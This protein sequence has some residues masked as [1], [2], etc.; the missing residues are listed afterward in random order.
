MAEHYAALPKGYR[1]AEY[2]LVR[3]LGAGGFGITYLAFDDRHNRPVA[4]KEYLP[5]VLAL[6]DPTDKVLPKSLAKVDDFEWG[7]DRFME[8][9]KTLARFRHQNL[10]DV[11]RFFRSNGT[12]YI[13]MEYAEGR[14]LTEVLE[15]KG[16]LDED[17]LKSILYP[18]LDGLRLVH[19]KDF[20]HRDIKPD[21][22]VVRRDG[23]PVLIDFGAARQDLGRKSRAV[24]AIVSAGYAPLEQYSTKGNQGPWTDI[25]ALGAVAYHC[26][27]GAPPPEATERTDRRDP[28]KPLAKWGRPLKEQQFQIAIDH[29]LC[30]NA[31]DRPRT[32]RAWAGELD[33]G[34][35]RLKSRSWKVNWA[36]QRKQFYVRAMIELLK[37]IGLSPKAAA[38]GLFGIVAAA[39]FGWGLMRAADEAAKEGA[40]LPPKLAVDESPPV[41]KETDPGEPGMKKAPA[42]EPETGEKKKAAE[43]KEKEEKQSLQ[44][45]GFDADKV[46]EVTW[47]KLPAMAGSETAYKVVA[48]D[49]G[50]FAILGKTDGADLAEAYDGAGNSL[51]K[52]RLPSADHTAA[53]ITA[54]PGGG[55]A[56]IGSYSRSGKKEALWLFRLDGAGKLVWQRLFEEAYDFFG[57]TIDVAQDGG[58]LVGAYKLEFS[59]GSLW[60]AKLDAEGE[61][62]WQRE[63]KAD[64]LDYNSRAAAASPEGGLVVAI[65]I[66][67][68]TFPRDTILYSL[69]AAGEVL[70]DMPVENSVYRVPQS[71]EVA[72]DGTIALAGK[73]RGASDGWE[74]FWVFVVDPDGEVRSDW[75]SDQDLGDEASAVV[76][77]DDGDVLVAGS[78]SHLKETIG[79]IRLVR[80]SRE[81]N[82]QWHSTIGMV[83]VNVIHAM[84]S[85]ADGGVILVGERSVGPEGTHDM[86]LLRLDSKEP[87]EK[88]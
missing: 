2:E 37:W 70:W 74:D 53:D 88:D 67:D 51:W 30:V 62:L 23:S 34:L 54:L 78:A 85:L 79:D 47:E 77:L 18:L 82:I 3:V 26:L 59:P 12:A 39:T 28:C 64:Q 55:I 56:G 73:T 8:E 17:E 35:R 44:A 46:L 4:I 15:R 5:D 27:T 87:K 42:E 50:G 38:V 72:G 6:R 86:W 80:L 7:L 58:F 24:T 29:A 19:A 14:N 69:D 61:I 41:G 75:K 63:F 84:A 36:K 31:K 16:T 10:I 22:I 76:F 20:L 52:W 60:T 49:G 13:V 65:A 25:Y 43:T 66:S 21:N 81:G 40:G 9:A 45:P 33:P 68:P 32:I 83:G 71:L 57:G 48:L 11:Y 1:F